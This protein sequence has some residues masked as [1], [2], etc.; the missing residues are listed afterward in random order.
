MR[1]LIAAFKVSMDM[2]F[3]GPGIMPTGYPPGPTTMTLERT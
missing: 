3:Q 2:K 1:R